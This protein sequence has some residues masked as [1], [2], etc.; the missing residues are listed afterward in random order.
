MV[1]DGLSSHISA[2]R[3][4]RRRNHSVEA[5]SLALHWAQQWEG[6]GVVLERFVVDA[7]CWVR[8]IRISN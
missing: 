5:A 3:M 4:S 6:I 2:L 1:A 8:Q 7:A